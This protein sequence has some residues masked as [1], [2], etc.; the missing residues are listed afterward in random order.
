M[1]KSN[2]RRG[3]GI[4]YLPTQRVCKT[5]TT[6][7]T[8]ISCV[9]EKFFGRKQV[10]GCIAFLKATETWDSPKYRVSWSCRSQWQELKPLPFNPFQ[11]YLQNVIKSIEWLIFQYKPAISLDLKG[12]SQ[13]VLNYEFLIYDF[14][15][16]VDS[17]FCRKR[18]DKGGW[19][20]LKVAKRLTVPLAYV[21]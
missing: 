20:V 6:Y 2:D 9:K 11:F 12:K 19:G 15:F 3:T 18:V 10:E 8:C 17:A 4:C 21:S 5:N 16:P 13:V 1:W 14:E 7:T